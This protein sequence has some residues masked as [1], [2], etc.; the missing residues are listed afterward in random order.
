MKKQILLFCL[1][2]F[3][4]S[5]AMANHFLGNTQSK[6]SGLHDADCKESLKGPYRGMGEA[7]KKRPLTA[8]T[9]F[10]YAFYF[11]SSYIPSTTTECLDDAMTRAE[12]QQ[13]QFVEVNA[14]VL[15]E[16]MARGDG[17]HLRALATLMGCDQRTYP[18]LAKM[19]QARFEW[20]IPH[21]TLTPVDLR[22]RLRGEITR[23]PELAEG[24][25]LI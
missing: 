1:V 12:K 7:F 22:D 20:L 11:S 9:S 10:T 6:G 19:A 23:H 21:E 4:T 14:I 3:A 2:L 24:C 8:M 17:D 18:G 15:I 13:L 25:K 16:Q 5:P